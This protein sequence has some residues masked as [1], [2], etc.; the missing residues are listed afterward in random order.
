[1]GKTNSCRYP[2]C[3]GFP[4]VSSLY[5]STWE[6]QASLDKLWYSTL[7]NR[8]PSKKARVPLEVWA[9]SRFNKYSSF[10]RAKTQQR[11]LPLDIPPHVPYCACKQPPESKGNLSIRRALGSAANRGLLQNE[12]RIK[13]KMSPVG[14]V[15]KWS[16]PERVRNPN[17]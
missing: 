4:A 1:M 2:C 6:I 10:H 7:A 8:A 9:F 17:K 16:N 11:Q 12:S 13:Q 5:I 14:F 3:N 15:S